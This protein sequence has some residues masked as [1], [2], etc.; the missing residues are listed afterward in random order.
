MWGCTGNMCR[1]TA[2]AKR[3]AS[4]SMK[5]KDVAL[6]CTQTVSAR[7]SPLKHCITAL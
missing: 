1:C 2:S 3:L 4:V 6:Q 5:W 7:T